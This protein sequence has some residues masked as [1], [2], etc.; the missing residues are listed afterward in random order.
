[1]RSLK[2]PAFLELP[3]T[4]WIGGPPPLFLVPLA[5]E[6]RLDHLPFHRVYTPVYASGAQATKRLVKKHRNKYSPNAVWTT[7]SLFIQ[8]DS[9]SS[10]LGAYWQP[11]ISTPEHHHFSFWI[12]ACL[13]AEVGET[14]TKNKGFFLLC[15]IGTPLPTQT[16]KRSHL[17]EPFLPTQCV[18]QRFRL[19]LCP[20]WIMVETKTTNLGDK[21]VVLWFL[22]SFPYLPTIIKFLS[23]SLVN[24]FMYY[25]QAFNL[26]FVKETEWNLYSLTRS[27]SDIVNYN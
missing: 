7:T 22:A 17:L 12:G 20:D 9:I 3:N 11:I 15:P 5:T 18:F 2:L 19:H 21:S 26:H 10:I 13:I 8:K 23:L 16:R 14:K 4:P 25:L 6:P 24:C 27:F 1:M